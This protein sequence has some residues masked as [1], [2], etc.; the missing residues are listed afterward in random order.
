MT[1]Y[2]GGTEAGREGFILPHYALRN[3]QNGETRW[4]EADPCPLKSRGLKAAC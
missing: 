1:S 3:V 2:L 4:I